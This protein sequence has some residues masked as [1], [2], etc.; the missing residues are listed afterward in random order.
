MKFPNTQ[1]DSDT[2]PDPGEN[3]LQIEPT[4]GQGDNPW[5][6]VKKNGPVQE[7]DPAPQTQVGHFSFKHFSFTVTTKRVRERCPS[8]MAGVPFRVLYLSSL[9]QKEGRLGE[10]NPPGSMKLNIFTINIPDLRSRSFEEIRL[11]ASPVE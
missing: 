1:N 11:C 6:D 10:M 8:W 2:P 5:D 9:E 4:E 7:T 3:S